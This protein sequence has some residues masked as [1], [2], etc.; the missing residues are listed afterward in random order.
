MHYFNLSPVFSAVLRPPPLPYSSLWR[1]KQNKPVQ[2]SYYSSLFRSYFT[3]SFSNNALQST[4]N[5]IKEP[6]YCLEEKFTLI[7]NDI[8]LLSTK[9]SFTCATGFLLTFHQS[10]PTYTLK[11]VWNVHFCMLR[12]PQGL[13]PI[14]NIHIQIHWNMPGDFSRSQISL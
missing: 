3:F 4:Q 11:K 10:N 9:V 7:L 12:N 2:L 8:M 1:T 13:R 6:L 14:L 5:K